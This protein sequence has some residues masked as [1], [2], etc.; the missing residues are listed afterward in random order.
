MNR[1]RERLKIALV[2]GFDD[3]VPAGERPLLKRAAQHF[4]PAVFSDRSK[5]E[6][7]KLIA[8]NPDSPPAR[9]RD[10]TCCGE[11][12]QPTIRRRMLCVRCF[13]GADR[14]PEISGPRSRG[15]RF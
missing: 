15:L 8:N 1:R 14:K 11:K 6:P 3:C 5:D 13:A 12:F 10:C 9:K 7:L 4:G 2:S